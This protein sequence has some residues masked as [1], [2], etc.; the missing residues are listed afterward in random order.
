MDNPTDVICKHFAI[1]FHDGGGG[2]QYFVTGGFKVFG[3]WKVVPKCYASV[4][5]GK[6]D[7]GVCFSVG[8]RVSR[9]L[10]GV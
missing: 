2:T 5:T 4:F 3:R 1:W 9:H 6:L 8:K 7:S 10:I